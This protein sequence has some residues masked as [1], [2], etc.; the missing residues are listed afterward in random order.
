MRIKSAIAP[1]AEALTFAR[2]EVD[3]NVQLLAVVE[4]RDNTVTALNL[5]ELFDRH[6]EDPVDLFNALGY[7]VIRERIE[8][9]PTASLIKADVDTLI[10]PL[11]LTDSHVAAGTNFAAHAEESS[12]EDGPFLFAKLVTPTP[13]NAT[14]SAADGLLDFEVELAFVTLSETPLSEVP[15][16]MGSDTGQRF[17]R[18][19]EIV[20]ALESGRRHFGRRVYH[21]KEFGGVPAG[22]KYVCDSERCFELRKND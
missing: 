22:R 8:S 20:T 18:S 12:V 4:Y 21:W 11:T 13:F 14:V 17:Y 10:L 7:E 15:K 1:P 16:Y 6:F 2:T 3:G 19:R 5:T 9:E